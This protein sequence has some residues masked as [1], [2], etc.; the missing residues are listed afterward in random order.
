[1]K[2][3]PTL[4]RTNSTAP[5]LIFM[6]GAPMESATDDAALAKALAEFA[7]VV[8]VEPTSWDTPGSAAGSERGPRRRRR[9]TRSEFVRMS[10]RF[11]R[12][13]TFVGTRPRSALTR[14]LARRARDRAIASALTELG[15]TS[16]A[17]VLTDPVGR[18]PV[19]VGG[20]RLL[21]VTD[22][23]VS[24]APSRGLSRRAVL[25][26][27]EVNCSRADTVAAVS[28]TLALRLHLYSK[29]FD[30]VRVVH[31]GCTLP[32]TDFETGTD[33]PSNNS[34]APRRTCPAVFVGDLDDS[35][36][37]DMLDAV[38]ATSLNIAVIGDRSPRLSSAGS[39][40]VDALL[41][42]PNVQLLG[43][44][45][46]ASTDGHP[47]AE[48]EAVTYMAAAA[49]GL[50]PHTLDAG[51][52]A[53]FPTHTLDYLAAGLP[54]VTTELPSTRWLDSEHVTIAHTP[55]E[56]AAAVSALA[57]ATADPEA[58]ASRR[59]LASLH[60]WSARATLVLRLMSIYREASAGATDF[61]GTRQPGRSRAPHVDRLR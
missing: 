58:V 42:R 22:D 41:S 21:Y 40:R 28:Q 48:H 56:F 49:V 1:M 8:W 31:A 7:H 23:W 3:L 4:S 55:D 5:T 50:A 57:R 54:V 47:A 25:R 43:S 36:D 26:S 11:S 17:V 33:A 46:G 13:R 52:R 39:A 34:G 59:E 16:D 20:H 44:R 51:T 2:S 29:T 27:I 53:R 30:A 24:S 32:E 61:G 19:D 10:P 15:T 6:A 38:A 9:T 35:I 37:Y 60:T 14:A 18:F 45:T 12:V